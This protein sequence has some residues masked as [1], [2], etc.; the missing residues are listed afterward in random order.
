MSL[1]RVCPLELFTPGIGG[2]MTTVAPGRKLAPTSVMRIR[3]APWL[4]N[5]GEMLVRD[6]PGT[7][8]VTVSITAFE[9]IP[10]LAASGL[11]TVTWSA[12]GKLTSEAKI[13]AVTW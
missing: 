7:A 2:E 12:A 8:V 13:V 4:A 9:V 6:G 3:S 10:G 5:S 1:A 11:N